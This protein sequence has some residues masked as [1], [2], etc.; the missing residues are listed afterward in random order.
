MY[1]YMN[2]IRFYGNS[3]KSIRNFPP[4]VK[5]AV[6]HQLDRVQRGLDP[7]DWKPMYVVGKGVKEIRI[8]LNGQFRVLYAIGPEQKILVLHAFRKKSQKTAKHDI[9]QA[10]NA[11]K[12]T[13]GR[14]VA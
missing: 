8:S 5:R 7:V 14:W 13:T 9:N 10:K 3:L 12:K 2:S 11:L 6:G 4:A 1:N